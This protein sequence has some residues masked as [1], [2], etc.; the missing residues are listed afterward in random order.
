MRDLCELRC[1]KK[2]GY[3]QE[4]ATELPAETY[5]RIHSELKLCQSQIYRCWFVFMWMHAVADGSEETLRRYRL[6]LKAFLAS[7]FSD[8]LQDCA[9]PEDRK[10]TLQEIYDEHIDDWK[11]LAAALTKHEQQEQQHEQ[12]A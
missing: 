12:K 2:N 7:R 1:L 5:A 9:T 6:V 4:F 3:F 8:W 11:L 10:R